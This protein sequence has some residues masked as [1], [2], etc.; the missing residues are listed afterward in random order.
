MEQ[1]ENSIKQHEAFMTTMDSNDEKINQV[2]T[3]SEKLYEENHYNADKVR[4][5]IPL[6]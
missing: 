4:A 6:L 3:Y 5:S 1:A 2:I